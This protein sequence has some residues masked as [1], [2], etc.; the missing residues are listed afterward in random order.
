MFLRDFGKFLKDYKVTD[1][2]KR[3]VASPTIQDSN[4]GTGNRFFS[5]P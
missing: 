5:S 4:L 3:L 1:S 2:E